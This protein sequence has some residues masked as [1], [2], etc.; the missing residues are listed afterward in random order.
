MRDIV[1]EKSYEV[2]RCI[3]LAKYPEELEFI[4][5]IWE[6][7]KEILEECSQDDLSGWPIA[8]RTTRPPGLGFI[9]PEALRSSAKHI[10]ILIPAV[11]GNLFAH[12]V[13]NA[14]EVQK[15]VV[16]DLNRFG[17]LFSVPKRLVRHLENVLP[18]MLLQIPEDLASIETCWKVLPGGKKKP[19]TI[20]EARILPFETSEYVALVN[21]LNPRRPFLYVR[22]EKLLVRARAVQVLVSLLRRDGGVCSYEEIIEHVWGKMIEHLPLSEGDR[23]TERVERTINVAL[24]GASPMLR[25]DIL[26]I[27]NQGYK[28]QGDLL[29]YCVIERE[30]L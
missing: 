9:G 1:L 24:K 18:D 26:N 5:L 13:S 6:S 2:S 7:I 11:L 8:E 20:K 19:I 12:E 27:P 3:V 30:L 29:R 28:V 10:M 14:D 22:G 25:R 15:S 21:M 16:A 17:E 23:Y 4:D